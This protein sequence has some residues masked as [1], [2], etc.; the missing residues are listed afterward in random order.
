M[1]ELLQFEKEKCRDL[2]R[3]PM[4]FRLKL[5]VCGIKLSKRDWNSFALPEKMQLLAM[6]CT[7]PQEIAAFRKK[8][9]AMIQACTGDSRDIPSLPITGNTSYP[10]TDKNNIPAMVRQQIH[11]L[12]DDAVNP[13]KWAML[14]DLQRFALIKLTQPGHLKQE[15]RLALQ[16]FALLPPES[17]DTR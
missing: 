11:T 7:T 13:E 8:L 10:W 1:N 15:L 3:F 17:A 5:D 12:A 4:Y 9:I 6:P 14:S 16:E 2:R